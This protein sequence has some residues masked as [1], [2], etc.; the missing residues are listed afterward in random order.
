MSIKAVIKKEFIQ[1]KRDPLTL[2]LLSFFPATLLLVFGYA[3]SFDVKDIGLGIY[4]GD[5][6]P[7]SASLTA[8]FASTEYFN[9][10]CHLQQRDSIDGALDKG[11]FDA[12]VVI[13][14]GFGKSILSGKATPLQVIIDGSDGR[15]AA[16]IEGYIAGFVNN[17]SQKII[18]KY[19]AA[20]GKK[21]EMPVNL[22]PR[23]WYNPE[24]KS[25]L[26]LVA[27]LIVF[28]LMIT[29]VISTSLSVVRERERGTME[30]LLVSPLSATTVIVGKTIPFL[31]IS[32]VATVVILFTGYFAFGVEVKGSYLLL[33]VASTLFILSALAQ[34]IL[35]STVTSSQQIAYFMAALSSILPALLLSG[36]IFPIAGMPKVIQAL[37]TIVPAK[38]FVS[39]LRG[40][41]MRGAGFS[42][43]VEDLTA[44]AVFSFVLLLVSVVRLKNVKL[45]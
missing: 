40:V 24:L 12:V 5:K 25:T 26:F 29:G 16:I 30:Q 39:L 31:I 33:F 37:T 8:A 4:D 23:I 21:I 9:V 2:F 43:A 36:F 38:Y 35:I 17:Y 20:K 14:E 45:V 11:E 42:S 44:L 6:T 18:T 27:G 32:L 10:K 13:P 1:I 19:F 28:I 15:S 34:G 22:E 41:M 7:S 3:L